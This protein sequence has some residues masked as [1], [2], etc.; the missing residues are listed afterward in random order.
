MAFRRRLFSHNPFY[1]LYNSGKSIG[2][3]PHTG[4]R[5]KP[6]ARRSSA[7]AVRTPVRRRP[8]LPP[9]SVEAQ[10]AGFNAMLAAAPQRGMLL[11]G[12]SKVRGGF[13]R[14]ISYDRIRKNPK[15]ICPYSESRT[16]QKRH[17]LQE[18]A[19]YAAHSNRIN[20]DKSPTHGR[21]MVC[22]ASEIVSKTGEHYDF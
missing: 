16:L 17:P 11:W 20:E 3:P 10:T 22:C 19:N 12:G 7:P 6:C 1:D 8:R 15:A 13:C 4:C 5:L 14:T 21:S 18:R 2:L 9:G